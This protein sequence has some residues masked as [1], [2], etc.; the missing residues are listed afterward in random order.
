MSEYGESA[1]G[2]GT[3]KEQECETDEEEIE[4]QTKIV[5]TG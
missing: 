1:I 5:S 3:L 2:G 4:F